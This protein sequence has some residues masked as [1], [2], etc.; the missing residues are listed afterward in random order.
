MRIAVSS[1][2]SSLDAWAGTA[3]GTCTQFLVVESES[4]DY[5]TISVP[6]DQIDP[7]K[8]SLYA[9]RALANQQVE[10]VLTGQIKDICRQTMLNLGMEV[11]DGI[12]RVTVREAVELYRSQGAPGVM[13]YQPPPDKIAVSCHGSSLDARLSQKGEPCTAFLL[14]EPQAMSFD[15]ITVEPGDSPERTSVNAVRAAAR[16]GATVVITPQ[17]RPACC[18]A[19]NALAI[20]VVLAPEDMT[21]REAVL[22]YERGELAPAS[23]R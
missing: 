2:G 9:I 17:I 19:L 16:G 14:V 11:I 18:T 15:L 8:V 4:M 23:Q 21:V 22:A 3:F 10:V 5:V 7:T 20:T 13:D 6:P 1:L 12:E